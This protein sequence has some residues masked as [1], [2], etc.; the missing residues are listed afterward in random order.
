[1]GLERGR[2]VGLQ[3][4]LGQGFALGTEAVTVRNF[5]R[6]DELQNAPAVNRFGWHSE[7]QITARQRW[8]LGR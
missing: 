5:M 8:R 1:M 2:L 7:L 3:L 4:L 6:T